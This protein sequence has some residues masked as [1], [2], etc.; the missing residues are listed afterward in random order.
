MSV[1][2]KKEEKKLIKFLIPCLIFM[3]C[4]NLKIYL[5]EMYPDDWKRIISTYNKRG[6]KRYER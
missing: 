4:R 6:T 3:I 1:V 2:T 5:Y